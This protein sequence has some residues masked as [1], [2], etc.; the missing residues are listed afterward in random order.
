M[1]EQA[2]LAPIFKTLQFSLK[3]NVLSVSYTLKKPLFILK[4]IHNGAITEDG[5]VVPFKP[6]YLF[7]APTELYLPQEEISKI[8]TWGDMVSLDLI[9]HANTIEKRFHALH[10]SY[11]LEK[12][13]LSK[14]FL[15]GEKGETILTIKTE[16]KPIFIRLP[17]KKE[18][19]TLKNISSWIQSS[20]LSKFEWIDAR[21]DGEILIF[22]RL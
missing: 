22:S 18:T 19:L 5:V 20:S 17:A 3:K 6:Y 11:R 9:E 4:D 10:T 1:K 2:L 14:I 16:K 13:D 21:F 7:F 12:I 8:T 15:T